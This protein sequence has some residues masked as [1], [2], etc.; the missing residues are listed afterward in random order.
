MAPRRRPPNQGLTITIDGP[1]GTG[2]STA[3]RHLAK[4]LGYLYLDTGAM[5]R[6]AALKALRTK[7][8]LTKKQALARLANAARIAFR[9]D[10]GHRVRVLLDGEDV[11]EEIRRPAISEA[12]S[13]V[14]TIPGVRRALVRQQQ[15][16][17][18][19]GRVVA[20]GR[21]TGTVVFPKA[22]LK[23]FLSANAAE[24]A[25]RRWQELREAE[26]P[27]SFDKVLVETKRRD[28]RDRQRAA[29]PLMAAKG[30]IRIDNTKLQSNEVLDILIGHVHRIQRRP[31]GSR[32][33]RR[34]L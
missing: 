31:A 16:I 1:A 12:A 14:A 26:H 32:F 34:P 7:V 13:V 17:G 5:Y 18:A 10:P 8:P 23:F 3:A 2:K 21:D 24:R 27:I 30:A 29:S 9:M 25:K 22:E 33:D 11:S 15:R 6:A 19:K 28:R 20:E 4:E